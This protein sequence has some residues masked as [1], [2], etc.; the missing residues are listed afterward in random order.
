LLRA[1]LHVHT[2]YSMDS[3]SSL[4]KI[5]ARCNE[6]GINCIAV[7]DHGTVEGALKIRDMAPFPVIVAEEILT[8]NGEVMG[9]F[10]EE[11]IPSKQ[12]IEKVIENIRA[13]GGL[14]S[15]PHPYDPFRGLKIDKDRFE[16]LKSNLDL[17]EVFNARCLVKGA[18]LKAKKLADELG[19]PGSAGSDAHSIGEIGNAYVEM[20]EFKDKDEFL[21]A[22]KQGIIKGHHS[23]I[24]VHLNSTIAKIKN[25]L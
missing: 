16:E 2:C 20:P 14:V 6:I 23:S 3:E 21:A 10:L 24:L 18:L 1:D 13:Q 5:I 8:P 25:F 19:I 11:T 15:I 17:V 7:A 22:L 9:M 4:E 12:S